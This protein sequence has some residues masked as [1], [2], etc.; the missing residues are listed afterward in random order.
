MHLMSFCWQRV[1]PFLKWV[2]ILSILQ[3]QLF[4]SVAV[5]TDVIG[6][7]KVRSDIGKSVEGEEHG[8][9]K[10]AVALLSQAVDVY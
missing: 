2:L 4:S 6:H 9:H 7:L 3:K 10:V 8:D 1:D 5:L